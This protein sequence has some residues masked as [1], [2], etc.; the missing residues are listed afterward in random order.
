HERPSVHLLN[1][2]HASPITGTRSHCP[3]SPGIGI[4][5]TAPV[6]N[7]R[8]QEGNPP[9]PPH[10]LDRHAEDRCGRAAASAGACWEWAAVG[11]GPARRVILDALHTL[12]LQRDRFVSLSHEGSEV[13]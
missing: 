13:G 10:I 11:V 8:R 4:T 5:M 2:Y 1:L 12:P 3:S 7:E 9:I 6:S